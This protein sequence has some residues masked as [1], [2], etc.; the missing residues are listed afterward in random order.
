MDNKRRST[1]INKALWILGLLSALRGAFLMGN[2]SLLGEDA[3]SLG[4]TSGLI[5]IVAISAAAA[6]TRRERK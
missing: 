1:N 3:A 2:G 6:A 4:R 5:G